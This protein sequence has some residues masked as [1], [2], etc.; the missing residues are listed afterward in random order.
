LLLEVSELFEIEFVVVVAWSEEVEDGW[1]WAEAGFMSELEISYTS[2][3]SDFSFNKGVDFV[4]MQKF[5]CSVA[6]TVD[7]LISIGWLMKNELL[8]RWKRSGIYSTVR[9]ERTI[10][11]R[12]LFVLSKKF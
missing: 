1:C 4:V 10:L 2:Q 7:V 5:A 6:G 12:E 11:F 3:S 9:S 8:R